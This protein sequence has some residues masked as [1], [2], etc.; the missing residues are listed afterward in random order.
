L[1]STNG[2][3]VNAYEPYKRD[4][5]VEGLQIAATIESAI[6]DA[7]LIVL[8]VGHKPLVAIDPVKIKNLVRGR[9]AVDTVNGWQEKIWKAAGFRFYRLGAA[10][11]ES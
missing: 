8:L 5:Q 4:L 10:A 1:L 9:L 7:D 6:S 2:A 3:Q 11:H